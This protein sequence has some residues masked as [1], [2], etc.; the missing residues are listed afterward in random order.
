M[1]SSFPRPVHS[2]GATDDTL[3]KEAAQFIV[4]HPPL[5]ILAGLITILREKYPS[6]YTPETMF[7]FS[8]VAERMC[9]LESRPD[10]R[11]RLLVE[12]TNAKPK[13]ARK[14]PLEMQ[15]GQV[16]IAIDAEDVSIKQYEL[17]HE[18]M[19]LA[20]YL[21]AGALWRFI[22]NSLPWEANEEADKEIVALLISSL[23]DPSR[24]KTE[25]S[26]SGAILTPWDLM[27][28]I[29]ARVWNQ[30]LPLDLRVKVH[31]A[32][33]EATRDGSE[34]VFA[35]KQV[36]E[37]VP[38]DVF[39]LHFKLTDL[40]KI[41]ELAEKRMGFE[42][43]P[44]PVEEPEPPTRFEGSHSTKP[45]AAD[46]AAAVEVDDLFPDTSGSDTD[47]ES[48]STPTAR[49]TSPPSAVPLA[50]ST[51]TVRP[52]SDEAD[53]MGAAPTAAAGGVPNGD[54]S[55]TIIVGE[56]EL[57]EADLAEPSGGAP[58]LDSE[59]SARDTAQAVE[60]ARIMMDLD[61]L[62][63]KLDGDPAKIRRVYSTIKCV[64]EGTFDPDEKKYSPAEVAAR[65]EQIR[66]VLVL[67]DL[68]RYSGHN[69]YTQGTLTLSAFVARLQ[70][71]LG[72][73]GSREGSGP[74]SI[75]VAAP[76]P[77]G[78]SAQPPPL[79]VSDKEKSDAGKSPDPS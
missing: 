51:E 20:L 64:R 27:H 69:S 13:T 45:P 19:E 53:P 68:A 11:Q 5:Q 50:S 75:Q 10:I 59:A 66:E 1:T 3:S 41:L 76:R 14:T 49:P 56:E 77:T 63:I 9:A 52:S 55:T 72:M 36:F 17:A 7:R 65:K 25:W 2:A 23:I 33:V 42:A 24:I 30:H 39:M 44:P 34:T 48:A 16:L 79:P 18:P 46:T 12:L 4:G 60:V 21:D 73:E 22:M 38:P 6:W 70:F 26:P 31:E 37:I 43:P 40:R 47:G 61:K 8:P 74:A 57:S 58:V 29:D 28:G 67:F 54:S 15:G 35:P 62:G 71:H 78:R 32:W